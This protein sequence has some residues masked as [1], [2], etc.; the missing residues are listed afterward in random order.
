MQAVGADQFDKEDRTE[1]LKK[2]SFFK[3]LYFGLLSGLLLVV[4]VIP[5]DE[6]NVSWDSDSGSSQ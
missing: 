2:S 6:E 5:Y 3:F 1:K 4:T